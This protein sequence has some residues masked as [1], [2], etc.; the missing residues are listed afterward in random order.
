MATGGASIGRESHDIHMM[1]PGSP[2]LPDKSVSVWN[3]SSPTHCAN[4]NTEAFAIAR[5]RLEQVR[6]R[7]YNLMPRTIGAV[8]NVPLYKLVNIA[9]RIEVATP[10]Q[11]RSGGGAHKFSAAPVGVLNSPDNV[12]RVAVWVQYPILPR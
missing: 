9:Q 2:G 6:R 12:G 10:T 8:T 5:T 11:T 4:G 3:A 7:L 1:E